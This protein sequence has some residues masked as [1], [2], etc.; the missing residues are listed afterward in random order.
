MIYI[1]IIYN[2]SLYFIIDNDLISDN[3]EVNTL[4]DVLIKKTS[5]DKLCQPPLLEILEIPEYFVLYSYIHFD[6]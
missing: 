2:Y 5:L 3:D 1:L 4:F 6:L